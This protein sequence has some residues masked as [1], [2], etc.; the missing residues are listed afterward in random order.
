MDF[1]FNKDAPNLKK[2]KEA[3]SDSSS[4]SLSRGEEDVTFEADFIE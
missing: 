2:V 1:S 4:N 3:D